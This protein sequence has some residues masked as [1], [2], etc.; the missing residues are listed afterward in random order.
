MMIAV[1]DTNVL[2]QAAISARGASFQVVKAHLEGQYEQAFSQNTL[3]ELARA[4]TIPRIRA[5][6]GWS[7]TE[8]REFVQLL[9]LGARVY[10]SRLGV[11]ASITRDV[12]DTKFLA[13]AV[14]SGADYL[15]TGDRRHLLRL[16]KYGRTKIV[17]PREFLRALEQLRGRS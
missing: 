12:T 2:V 8:I 9:C 15:V 4:L 11:A 10:P 6:H 16:R 1:L 17:T 13:L 5:R 3:E 14:E 7:D